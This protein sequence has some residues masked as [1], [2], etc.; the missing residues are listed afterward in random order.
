MKLKKLDPPLGFW[1]KCHVHI[2]AVNILV[3]A[4]IC[5]PQKVIP[6]CR[7]WVTVTH[8]T[9]TWS[10]QYWSSINGR[11]LLKF[12]SNDI[13]TTFHNILFHNSWIFCFL[14]TCDGLVYQWQVITGKIKFVVTSR[15]YVSFLFLQKVNCRNNLC[16]LWSSELHLQCRMNLFK[17]I[18]IHNNL[19]CTIVPHENHDNDCQLHHT[20]CVIWLVS[21]LLGSGL[22]I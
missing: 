10:S 18:W 14:Q 5:R 17:F 21:P 15:Q 13:S 22:Q 2:H 6:L 12:T 19:F 3:N 1:L 4:D 16:F 20:F 9:L 7:L 11:F 8:H